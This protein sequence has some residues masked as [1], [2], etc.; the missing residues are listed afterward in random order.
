MALHRIR[1]GLDLPIA[2]APKQALGTVPS[3]TAVALLPRDHV[4]IRPR[5]LVQVGDAVRRGQPLFED[6]KNPGVL[7][8]SPGAGRVAAIHRGERRA[9]ESVVIELS[10]RERAGEPGPGE[11]QEF[12]TFA[13]RD[14]GALSPEEIEALLLESG[15]WTSF[16]TRPFGK[17]P[18]PGSRPRSIFVAA[19]N[20]HPLAADV[21]VAVA[22]REGAFAAGVRCIARLVAPAPSGGPRSSGATFV[23]VRSGSRL[24]AFVPE[25]ARVEE[26][27][28]PHPA[29]TP[30]LHIHVLD[31][32]ARGKTVWY[33]DYEDAIAIGTLFLTGRLDPRRA[34]SLAGPAVRDPR[35][36]WT[37]LGASVDELVRG[38]LLPGDV[39]VISGSV[40]TGREAR[41]PVFGY[42][43]RYHLQVSALEEGRKREF[44][45]W[46]APGWDKFSAIP[47]F[48]S[49][50]RPRR[51]F[52]FTTST[53]GSRRAI[54][55]FGTYERVFPFD[56]V[57]TYLLRAIASG[58]VEEA[59][60]LG[61]LELEE[62]DVALASF[63][64]PGKN[65]FGSL[66]RKTLD[67]IEQ[68][69]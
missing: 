50:L 24:K 47:M 12:R 42:L 2:G 58:D 62:E 31:P 61:C 21:D 65:D 10:E 46:L 40:L 4:G 48:L 36:L 8:T 32:V 6:K 9:Y 7:Y 39:R 16:R 23:C 20:T 51:S 1:K 66:L 41:G 43:G 38:E 17:V 34:I 63:V 53:N 27:E 54:V 11:L 49:S 68:E 55:P 56:M 13:G 52:A 26:F 33:L 25:G 15:L 60:K 22:G 5:M 45:G 30:G 35:L 57:A 28:G 19:M 14:P 64:C 18:A 29:G 44:L 3:P 67:A 37:R 69:G 59:E